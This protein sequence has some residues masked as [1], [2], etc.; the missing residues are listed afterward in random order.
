MRQ[1]VLLFIQTSD[2]GL[3]PDSL[4]D[5]F[6]LFNPTLGEGPEPGNPNTEDPEQILSRSLEV[7]KVPKESVEPIFDIH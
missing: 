4:E 7:A 1:R 2:K 6:S 3:D 5:E